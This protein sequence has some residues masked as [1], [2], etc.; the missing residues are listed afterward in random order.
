M[1]QKREH[2]R[3]ALRCSVKIW[4]EE[5]GEVVVHTK[6]ISVGGLFLA[7]D[8]DDMNIPPVGTILKGQVQGMMQDAPI[9]TMEVVRI[10][11][12]G[13]GLRYLTDTK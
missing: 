3:T 8:P 4:N 10:T 1:G 13:I 6:D 9:V 7:M 2:Q 12:G 11:S 5:F